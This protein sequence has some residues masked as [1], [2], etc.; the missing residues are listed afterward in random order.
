[1]ELFLGLIMLSQFCK[2][3]ASNNVV[4]RKF[5]INRNCFFYV[6][7]GLFVLIITKRCQGPKV[8]WIRICGSLLN[9]FFNERD[10]LFVFF[11]RK[12]LSGDL[13][14]L[15]GTNNFDIDAPA[16]GAS[17]I[18]STGD[19]RTTARPFCVADSILVTA[20]FTSGLESEILI[21]IVEGADGDRFLNVAKSIQC[22]R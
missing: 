9:H 14:K 21:V 2:S 15:F 16:I 8:Q 19:L 22:L 10:C 12:E 6:F 18:L 17:L 11:L 5:G 13:N 20:S 4:I 1:M 3:P 7:Q